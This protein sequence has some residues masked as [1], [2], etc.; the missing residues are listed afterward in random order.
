MIHDE[1]VIKQYYLDTDHCCMLSEVDEFNNAII[2]IVNDQY[3][4]RAL[5]MIEQFKSTIQFRDD[6]IGVVSSQ[7]HLYYENMGFAFDTFYIIF[8]IV[9]FFKI[10]R[11]NEQILEL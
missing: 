5:A 8:I 3:L 7:R 2:D 6:F 11:Y 4:P 9:W 10:K 1:P